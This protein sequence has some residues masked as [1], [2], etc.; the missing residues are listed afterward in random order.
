M[1]GMNTLTRSHG[2]AVM[3]PGITFLSTQQR[4]GLDSPCSAHTFALA[5]KSAAECR[6][7]FQ[8]EL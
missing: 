6:A 3:N 5:A 2:R 7:Q 1:E 4:E 8:S